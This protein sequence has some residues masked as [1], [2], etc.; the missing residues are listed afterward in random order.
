SFTVVS[1]AASFARG[2]GACTP[3]CN[4]ARAAQAG[5]PPWKAAFGHISIAPGRSSA[6]QAVHAAGLEELAGPVAGVQARHRDIAAGAWRMHE[7]AVA[8]V[9]ADVVDALAAAAEEHQVAGGKRR[10]VHLFAV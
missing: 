4:G 2:A 6:V 1:M 7:L 5:R 3:R 8:D 9:D 10:A